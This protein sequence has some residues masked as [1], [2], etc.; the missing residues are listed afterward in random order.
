MSQKDQQIAKQFFDKNFGGMKLA[1]TRHSRV[2]HGEREDVF[3]GAKLIRTFKKF[4]KLTNI[5]HSGEEVSITYK[6]S[7]L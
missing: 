4:L 1:F 5:A 2:D 3:S 7:I 6:K